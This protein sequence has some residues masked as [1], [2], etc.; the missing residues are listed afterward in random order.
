MWIPLATSAPV[1]SRQSADVIFANGKFG[2][3]VSFKS[4]CLV[5]PYRAFKRPQSV[6]AVPVA[7]TPESTFIASLVPNATA[8]A[9][10]VSSVPRPR[11][12]APLPLASQRLPN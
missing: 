9:T 6:R 10:I 1:E 4:R 11:T 3:T 12:P 5:E 2:E 7:Y 8:P